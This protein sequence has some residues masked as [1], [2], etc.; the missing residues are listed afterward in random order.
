MAMVNQ[1]A[2]VNVEGRAPGEKGTSRKLP[3]GSGE[4]WKSCCPTRNPQDLR[5]QRL[6]R[7]PLPDF[8]LFHPR[9]S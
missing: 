4:V 7:H 1:L 5:G 2:S 6:I 3:Q 9:A 8:T